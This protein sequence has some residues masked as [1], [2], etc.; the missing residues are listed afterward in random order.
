MKE[1]VEECRREWKRLG[2]PDPIADE[3]AADLAADLDEA[4]AEGA[5][6][7]DVLGSAALDPRSF[8]GAWAAERGVARDSRPRRFGRL[9]RRSRIPAAVAA[10]ALVA[11]T[12]TVLVLV[13]SPG[14]AR[15]ALSTSV[16]PLRVGPSRFAVV[17]PRIRALRTRGAHPIRPALPHVLIARPRIVAAAAG[18]A[19]GVLRTAGSVL[20][21]AGL[22][23]I[24]LSTLLWFAL[25]SAG[26]SLRPR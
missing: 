2:V 4:E 10:F 24:V 15:L 23:G 6:A 22:A 9:L 21:V 14:S 3:M 12:G 20:L 5:S 7:E 1:F 26:W 13:A 11:I 8:A 19:D 17:T 25:G 16:G 18:T